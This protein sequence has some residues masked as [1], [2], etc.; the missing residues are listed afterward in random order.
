MS[1]VAKAL[2]TKPLESLNRQHT[3]LAVAS[4][5]TTQSKREKELRDDPDFSLTAISVA[6]DDSDSDY[7]PPESSP[8]NRGKRLQDRGRARRK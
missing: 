6:T 7:D 2:Q 1:I 4:P 8:S 3:L 5:S